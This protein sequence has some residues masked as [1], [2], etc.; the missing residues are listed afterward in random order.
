[1]KKSS[2]G[3]YN[4]NVLVE[5]ANILARPLAHILNISLQTGKVPDKFKVVK[6]IPI[7]KKGERQM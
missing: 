7:Y 1:M 4:L 2:I 6:V 5:T 3:N